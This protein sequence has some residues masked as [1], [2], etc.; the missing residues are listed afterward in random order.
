MFIDLASPQH[1]QNEKL[2]QEILYHLKPLEMELMHKF[3]IMD[4][5]FFVDPSILLS[6]TEKQE[7]IIDI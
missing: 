5:L 1:Q 6:R 3:S 7:E 4:N 2:L